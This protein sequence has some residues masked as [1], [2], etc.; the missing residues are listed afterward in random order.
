[1]NTA[2]SISKIVYNGI[3]YRLLR[4]T[5]RAGNI[6]TISLEITHRCF[7]RCSMCN[8]WKIPPVVADLDLADWLGLLASPELSDLRELDLTGGEPFLRKDLADLLDGICGLKPEHF[9]K[10][11]TVAITT[12]GILTDRVLDL[13]SRIVGPLQKLGVDLVLACG[14]DSASE[15]HDR[16]RGYPGAWEK[17]QKTLAGLYRIRASYQNLVLGIKTTVIPLNVY[18]LDSLAD[19][20]EKNNLFTIV[21]PRIITPN[22]FGN[23]DLENDLKFNQAEIEGMI[24]FYESPRFTWNGHRKALLEYLRTGRINK[25]CSAGFNTLFVRHNG[26]VFPCPV[27]SFALGNIKNSPLGELFNGTTACQF[28]KNIKKFPECSVCTEP[29]MERIAWPFEGFT[30]LGV[31]AE[32]GINDFK[33]Q[34]EHTRIDKYLE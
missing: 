7:C 6:Q 16:I 28:R 11:Q 34:I 14:M 29:G 22:R 12:N 25:P 32:T 5:G 9:P 31:L 15:L 30:L 21:S 10:L 19:F 24:R 17:L 1:L 13:V 26:D 18:E 23:S 3:R 8:I 4:Y 2:R 33:R 20:A 27:I